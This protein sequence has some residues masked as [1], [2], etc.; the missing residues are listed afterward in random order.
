MKFQ[1]AQR[2]LGSLHKFK[3]K[4]I[5]YLLAKY[6]TPRTCTLPGEDFL[7]KVLEE[8]WDTLEY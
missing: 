1:E 2:L 5:L 8:L 7:N 3:E 4:E 6:W